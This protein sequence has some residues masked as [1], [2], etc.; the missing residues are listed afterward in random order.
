MTQYFDSADQLA[1]EVIAA[2]GKRIV[3]GLPVG[4]GKAAHFA[5]ALY[6]HAARDDS[7]EL[8]IFT[9][10]TLEV[11]EPGSD[12][13]RRFLTPLAERLWKGWPALRYAEDLRQQRLPPNVRVHE[14]YFRPGAYLRNA[15]A[16]QSYASINYTQVAAELLRLGVNVIGQLVAPDGESAGR[17]S[18]GSNPEVTLDLLPELERRRAAGQPFAFVAEVN[19]HMPYMHGDA[20]LDAGRFDFVL[21]SATCAYPL[22][23]LPRRAVTDRDYATAMHVASLVPDGGTLQL[24][25]GSL[26]EALAHCLILRHRSPEVFRNVLDRLPGGPASG[27][28]PGVPLETGAF[29]EGLYACTELLSDAVWALLDADIIRRPADEHDPTLVHAGFFVGSSALYE[30]LR[31]DRKS[32]V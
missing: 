13:E 5:N 19:P 14:F 9:A 27:R 20:E 21:A 1:G 6:E 25:I 10:L 32:V 15:T 4:L 2:V 12:L 22:F 17:F 18:L 26:S 3:L 16:Q 30:A 29:R 24:G 28:R 31:T 23:G 8:T 7:I 11:P